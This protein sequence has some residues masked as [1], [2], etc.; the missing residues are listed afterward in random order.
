MLKFQRWL[1]GVFGQ[2]SANSALSK[3]TEWVGKDKNAISRTLLGVIDAENLPI[4]FGGQAEGFTWAKDVQQ[5]A[6]AS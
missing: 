3:N 4:Q 1:S 5:E 2:E 6:G